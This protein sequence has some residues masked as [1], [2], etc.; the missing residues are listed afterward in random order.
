MA[1][2]TDY[3]FFI[4][5]KGTSSDI[6]LQEGQFIINPE[7]GQTY[8]DIEVFANDEDETGEVQRIKLNPTT[9]VID[10]TDDETPVNGQAVADFL[11]G[12]I[13]STFNAESNNAISAS[14]I[15]QILRSLYIVP[16]DPIDTSSGAT[17]EYLFRYRGLDDVLTQASFT[18][19][20]GDKGEQGVPGGVVISK[21]YSSVSDMNNDN[22]LNFPEIAFVLVLT[23]DSQTQTYTA[24]DIYLRTIVD[25]TTTPPTITREFLADILAGLNNET[26]LVG[27]I[28]N[29][30][31]GT[32]EIFNGYTI[33]TAIGKYSHAEG[34]YATA[35]GNYSHAEG[36]RTTASGN[37]SHAEG[38]YTIA[39]ETSSHA[40][41]A[42]ATA[43]GTGSHAEG[44]SATAS[45][46]YSHAEGRLTTA[47]GNNSH[48]E[49]IHTI[50]SGNTSHAEG[51]Y[52]LASGDYQ[53]VSGK[54]NIADITSAEIIGWGTGTAVADRKNIR[55]L[56]PN[57]DEWLSGGL[58][59]G[60]SVEIKSSDINLGYAATSISTYSSTGLKLQDSDGTD[61]SY[62]KPFRVPVAYPSNQNEYHDGTGID[63]GTQRDIPN[64]QDSG[65]ET[66]V[67]NSVHLSID[68][69]GTQGVWVGAP[70]A[71]RYAL[72]TPAGDEFSVKF[73]NETEITN[74]TCASISNKTSDTPA[75]IWFTTKEE[76]Q[77][78]QAQIVFTQDGQQ[79]FRTRSRSSTN[80]SWPS[81]STSTWGNVYGLITNRVN[82]S[83]DSLT[84]TLSFDDND[85]ETGFPV[86]TSST[87]SAITGNTNWW[88]NYQVRWRDKMANVI[89]YISAIWNK[90]KK[91]T[92]LEIVAMREINDE[93]LYHSLSLGIDDNGNKVVTCSAPAWRT[94]IGTNVWENLTTYT[95]SD[96]IANT[97][98]SLPV[99]VIKY[100][101]AIKLCCI[102]IRV[103]INTASLTSGTSLLEGLPKPAATMSGVLGSNNSNSDNIRCALGTDGKLVVAGAHNLLNNNS[104][105]SMNLTYPYNT[106]T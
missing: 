101:E 95:L 46:T 30:S 82:K 90:N 13:D 50:A 98:G 14:A 19:R 80:D 67:Y 59:T 105:F 73:G 99:I 17:N 87:N 68:E 7:T 94:A 28:D 79:V 45:G 62:V 35:S 8:T 63:V 57:G 49:G 77:R 25:S 38:S 23:E 64:Y 15:A 56:S 6:P 34:Y 97:S 89:G 83:G 58:E 51:Y 106:L 55:T 84:G 70:E 5:V 76:G 44:G 74:N 91:A 9:S 103:K 69:D 100:N 33:N 71:W 29:R 40:E 86:I 4:P 36:N 41:G 18:V 20:N 104:W 54:Y 93:Q 12:S 75:G 81:W 3:G 48:A 2:N 52:T 27:K 1:N 78:Q 61:I 22:S 72:G 21:I 32:G 11:G 16:P 24:A 42:S 96:M 39:S 92:G 10:P 37:G 26:N 43:S 31:D 53:H 47:S 60:D 66:T 88:H 85:S 102:N 65:N